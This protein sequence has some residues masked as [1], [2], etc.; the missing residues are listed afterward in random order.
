MDDATDGARSLHWKWKMCIFIRYFEQKRFLGR[1][2]VKR[3]VRK[4]FGNVKA[5]FIWL[6]A[7]SGASVWEYGIEPL[8][9]K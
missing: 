5:G 8:G 2:V 9:Y 4:Q 6:R 7:L 1:M 3:Y